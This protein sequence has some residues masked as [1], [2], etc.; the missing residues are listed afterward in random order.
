M[1]SLLD[2]TG[3]L[4]PV[5]R[6][7]IEKPD[8]LEDKTLGLLDISKAKGDIFLDRLQELFTERGVKVRRYKKPTF[9][10]PA[11][12]VLIQEIAEEVDLVIEG[13]AD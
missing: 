12:L 8:S 9:A 2:P 6:F 3:E 1:Q 7:P 10:K 4:E 11:P 13:L 5:T